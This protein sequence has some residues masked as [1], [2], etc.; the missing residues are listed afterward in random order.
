MALVT[1]SGVNTAD[2]PDLGRQKWNLNDTNIL[3]ALETHVA[4]S[5]AHQAAGDTSAILTASGTQTLINKT[6][7]ST[8]NTMSV[9]AAG[10]KGAITTLKHYEHNSLVDEELQDFAYDS[11]EGGIKYIHV[12]GDNGI[13]VD[14]LTDATESDGIRIH[15]NKDAVFDYDGGQTLAIN[16]AS[17]VAGEQFKLSGK[18]TFAGQVSLSTSQPLKIA[19]ASGYLDIDSTVESTSTSTGSIQT[20]G[21]LGVAKTI[22]VGKDINISGLI[23]DDGAQL[24]LQDGSFDTYLQNTTPAGTLYLEGYNI[25]LRDSANTSQYVQA[26]GGNITSTGKGSIGSTADNTLGSTDGSFTTAGG[27]YV[28]KNLTIGTGARINSTNTLSFNETTEKI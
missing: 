13:R 22:Y 11:S 19:H 1:L 28:A 23:R 8:T 18:S 7:D 4:S 27:A 16:T 14:K 25:Q 3:A 6:I 2:T 10:L 21:G 17:V 20:L 12:K 26:D 24:H 15:V 5:S 9:Y